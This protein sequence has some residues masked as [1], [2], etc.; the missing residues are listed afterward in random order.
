MK[1]IAKTVFT[2]EVCGLSAEVAG[3]ADRPTREC[4]VCSNAE[5]FKVEYVTEKDSKI[6]DAERQLEKIDVAI[7][8]INGKRNLLEKRLE[9]YRSD[10][11]HQMIWLNEAAAEEADRNLDI[12]M[13]MVDSI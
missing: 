13:T 6:Q 1:D 11:Y 5:H 4:F 7:S 9:F 10:M 8:H 12:L 2:C 3:A